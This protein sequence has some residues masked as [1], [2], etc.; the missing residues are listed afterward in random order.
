MNSISPWND[1]GPSV[2]QKK[3][4]GC[5]PYHVMSWL[6]LCRRR[7]PLI[8]TPTPR[9][10]FTLHLPIQGKDMAF[11]A[12]CG[13]LGIPYRELR[14]YYYILYRYTARC[15][16]LLGFM[17]KTLENHWIRKCFFCLF[18]LC[19]LLLLLESYWLTISPCSKKMVVCAQ[20]TFEM[21]N[22]GLWDNN[23]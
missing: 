1:F 15:Y 16:C 12:L 10:N 7:A 14:L 13:D 22:R 2:Y 8:F 18:V 17:Q 6:C 19:C 20:K 23:S 11:G 4:L 9:G 5:C 21:T 3:L